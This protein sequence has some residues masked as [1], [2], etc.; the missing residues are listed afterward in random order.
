MHTLRPVVSYAMHTMM[1][2]RGRKEWRRAR[3]R[4]NCNS[5]HNFF[6]FALFSCFCLIWNCICC[7]EADGGRKRSALWHATSSHQQ[8]SHWWS[9]W[10][11]FFL[12]THT[13]KHTQLFTSLYFLLKEHQ[14]NRFEREGE[15]VR[16]G[17]AEKRERCPHPAVCAVSLFNSRVV[18]PRR[19][20]SERSSWEWT[21]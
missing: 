7:R 4:A 10:L 3:W 8:I 15:R 21:R 2:E 20:Q 11:N 13:H 9:L 17:E 1:G 16:E 18:R 6:S 14:A 12:H 19:R 5:V